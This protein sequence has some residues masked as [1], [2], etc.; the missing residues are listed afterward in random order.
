MRPLADTATHHVLAALIVAAASASASTPCAAQSL[1]DASAR[2]APQYLTYDLGSPI[3]VRVAQLALPF[4]VVAPLGHALTVDIASAWVSSTVNGDAVSSSISGL[5]DTQ[6]RASWT[7]GTDAV[8]LTAGMNLPTGRSTVDSAQIDAAGL[9][10]N[11]FLAFPISNMGTGFG[12]TGGVAVARPMGEW[13]VG[14]GASLRYSAEYEPYDVGGVR[15]QYEP[16]NEY[17]L[18]LGGDR[19]LF[20]GRMALGATLAIFGDDAAGGTTYA[21]GNRYILQGAWAGVVRALDVTISAW[22]LTRGEG[23]TV[24]GVAPWENIANLAVAV[25]T[26]MLGTRVEPSLEVRT[27]MRDAGEQASGLHRGNNVG[28]LAT[29]AVRADSHALGLLLTPSFG[30]TLG[31]VQAGGPDRA[32]L[33]GFRLSIGARHAR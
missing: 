6:L 5:T 2:A 8:V 7:L 25:S 17:R 23:E 1:L 27:W 30:Y 26:E 9:I 12:G 10:G 18:R 21:T 15:A 11:D 31:G 28:R 24:S 13:N 22:N 20:G 4:A 29:L 19:P 32:S 16:G 3:G 33:S 14:V